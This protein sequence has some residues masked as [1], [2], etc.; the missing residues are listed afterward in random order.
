MNNKIEC[1]FAVRRFRMLNS[2]VCLVHLFHSRM[3]ELLIWHF[4][5]NWSLPASNSSI[6]LLQG[7]FG[8]ACTRS[9]SQWVHRAA[10]VPVGVL[11]LVYLLETITCLLQC[12]YSRIILYA[13]RNQVQ[14]IKRCGNSVGK[15]PW[16][17]LHFYCLEIRGRPTLV[18]AL[19][20]Y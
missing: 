6:L 10:S 18:W 11:D 2:L 4:C 7:Y 13:P 1:K 19:V 17:A 16:T 14:Y 12:K 20:L 3:N 8:T 5:K 9:S 15:L